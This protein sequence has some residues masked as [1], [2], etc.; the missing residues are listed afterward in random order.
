MSYKRTQKEINQLNNWQFAGIITLLILFIALIIA[1]WLD[2]IHW[3]AQEN[4][5]IE[6]GFKGYIN[7]YCYI[8]EDNKAYKQEIECIGYEC[9]YTSEKVLMKEEFK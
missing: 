9:Y 7:G 3:G 8:I 4:Y 1:S 5:C 2:V 6:E